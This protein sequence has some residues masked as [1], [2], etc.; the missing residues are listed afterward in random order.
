MGYG[1]YDAE[2]A[3]GIA[4]AY[5]KCKANKSGASFLEIRTKG[6]RVQTSGDQRRSPWPTGMLTWISKGMTS[7]LKARQRD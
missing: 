7:D 4:E 3:E 6:G 2:D 5:A 1:C